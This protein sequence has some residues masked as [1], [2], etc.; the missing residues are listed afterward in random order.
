[1][2]VT[3][4]HWTGL[5]LQMWGYLIGEAEDWHIELMVIGKDACTL[6]G[7]RNAG[8]HRYDDY[9]DTRKRLWEVLFEPA[10]PREY[11]R[12]AGGTRSVI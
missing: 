9:I 10:P 8:L 12:C 7:T 6:Q 4:N 1:M 5:A 3:F 2:Y 11:P